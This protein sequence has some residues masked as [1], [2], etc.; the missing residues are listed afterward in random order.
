MA[1]RTYLWAIILV[2]MIWTWS[3]LAGPLSL[4]GEPDFRYNIKADT[5]S[6]DDATKTYQ[7]SGHATITSG[8]KSLHADAV[9]FNDETKEANARG[10]V[11]FFSGKDW[12]TGARIEVNLGANTGTVHNGT[13]FIYESHFYVRGDEI[14]KTG[15][16][17]YYIKDGRFTTCEGDSPDWEITGKDLKVTIEG[18][19][20]V[21]HAAFRAKSIPVLYAPFLIFPAKTK[22]QSGLLVPQFGYSDRNGFEYNQPLF[23]AINESSDLTLYEHYMSQRGFKHGLEYR[24]VLAPQSHGTV[25]YDFLYDRNTDGLPAPQESEGFGADDENRI[26]RKRWWFRAKTNQELPAEFKAKLD[27]DLVSDQDYL[28]EFKTGYSGYSDS[29]RCFL[30]EFGRGIED[31]TETVRLNQLNLNRIWDQYSLNADMRWYDN[32]IARQNNDP[33]T[34]L[35]M[36]PE[37][38]F[39]GSRQDLYDTSFYFDLDSSYDYFW[40]DCGTKGHRADVYARLYYPVTL[41]RHLDFEPSFGVRET[42]WLAEKYENEDPEKK[43]RFQARNIFYLKADLSTEF[44]RV[45]DVNG[46]TVDKIKHAVRPQVVFEYVPVQDQEDFPYFEGIDRIEE[47]N[48][49]TYS[50]TNYFTTRKV[51]RRNLRTDQQEP[52]SDY[53][54][55]DLCR[56]KFLQSYD[57]REAR[58]HK[59][60]GK[61][62]PF[63]DIR[64]EVEFRLSDY[65]DLDADAAWSPYDGKFSGYNAMLNL[66]NDRGDRASVDYVYA[67]DRTKSILTEVYVNLFDPVSAY[68]KYER[69]L[70]AGQTIE[71]VVG[72]KYEPQCWSLSVGFRNDR[73]MDSREYLVEISLHGLGKVGG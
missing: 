57:I 40:R 11:R 58:G 21:K 42:V 39:A 71:T 38:A 44:S 22:R 7:A 26:N 73:A 34:T 72:F 35:Q 32:V 68:C 62:R 2:V 17:S 64:C 36:L 49:V 59:N 46:Q 12:V 18:Y 27:L 47:K 1:F 28:R 29:D 60:G 70:R 5:L 41:L 45:F 3:A 52:S 53:L 20:T 31:D 4:G 6:Y 25:M 14:Q 33:D 51:R 56:I 48:L 54:Y 23:W 10:N 15:E 55:E 19:G 65:V 67:R 43:D 13:L 37:I 24:Y 30:E 16:D 63:S 69:D 50:V 8:N 9:D 66:A 61:K